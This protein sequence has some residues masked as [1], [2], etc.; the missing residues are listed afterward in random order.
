[1]AA[2][3]GLP[4]AAG[5]EIARAA[6]APQWPS[7]I[8]LHGKECIGCTES[9]LRAYHPTHETLILDVVSLDYHETLSTGAG[10]QVEAY[11]RKI[12]QEQHGKHVLVTEGATPTRDGGV[13]CMVAGRPHLE[14]VKEAAEGAAAIIAIGSCASSGGIQAA[15]PNPTGAVPMHEVLRGKTVIDIPA[16]RPTPTISSPPSCIS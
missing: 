2:T 1:M 15:H 14:R 4:A 3:L 8:W 10:H 6:S 5:L 11:L 7:V 12:M 16:A 9:L 13:S